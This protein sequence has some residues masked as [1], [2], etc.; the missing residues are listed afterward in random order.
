M[1]CIVSYYD[2]ILTCIGVLYSARVFGLACGVAW[3][4]AKLGGY[5]GENIGFCA[6]CSVLDRW[7]LIVCTVL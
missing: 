4:D 5:L 6:G 3:L 1:F 2:L 7:F